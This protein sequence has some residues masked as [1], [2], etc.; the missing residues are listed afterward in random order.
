M[1][2]P[3]SIRDVPDRYMREMHPDLWV[4]IKIFLFYAI[5]FKDLLKINLLMLRNGERV[6][7]FSKVNFSDHK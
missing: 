6:I 5:K 4:T 2:G 7:N 1:T 3:H